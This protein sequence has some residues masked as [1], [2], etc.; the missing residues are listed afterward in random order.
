MVQSLTTHHI[1]QLK[2]MVQSLT[3]HHIHQL[4]AMVQSLTTH[5][6]HQLKPML[7]NLTTHRI[8]QLKVKAMGHNLTT[9]RVSV[10]SHRHFGKGLDSVGQHPEHKAHGVQQCD[11]REGLGRG[12]ATASGH[13]GD[14]GQGGRHGGDHGRGAGADAL[15]DGTLLQD[16][17]LL[18]PDVGD[19]FGEGFLP[20]VH[21][22]E[23]DAG[24]ELVH[25]AYLPGSRHACVSKFENGA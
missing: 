4:K 15:N 1:H 23:L 22:D 18:Q 21:L 6:I 8:H 9:H 11:E 5:R 20:G 2:A 12:Q 14:E 17:P 19:L 3:T 13:D 10:Q 7:H 25:H 24:E 16:T